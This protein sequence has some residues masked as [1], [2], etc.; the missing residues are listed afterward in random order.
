M[1]LLP[2]EEVKTVCFVRDF[3]QGEPRR[4]SRLF[5]SRPKLEGLWLRMRFR[6]GDLMD[7]VLN[8]N[9]LQLDPHGFVVVPPDPGYQN[10]RLFVPRAAL[11]EVSVLGVVGSALR[12]GRSPKAKPKSKE[13]LEMFER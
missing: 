13:Q 3:G 12:T 7:G 9:L 11:T 2:Y 1:L 5:T 8:N 6:D 10:Q 4:D